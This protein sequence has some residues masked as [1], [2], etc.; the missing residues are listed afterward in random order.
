MSFLDLIIF[1]LVVLVINA[2]WL[3][4]CISAKKGDSNREEDSDIFIDN[5]FWNDNKS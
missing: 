1:I 3:L 5:D 2:F 4:L